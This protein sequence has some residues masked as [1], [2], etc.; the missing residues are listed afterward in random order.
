[1]ISFLDNTTCKSSGCGILL[2]YFLVE[3]FLIGPN[4]RSGFLL[5]DT[6]APMGCVQYL[7]ARCPMCRGSLTQDL[8]GPLVSDTRQE[9]EQKFEQQQEREQ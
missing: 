4:M 9:Q 6:A 3:Q 2:V 7:V 1:M 5:V 8:V